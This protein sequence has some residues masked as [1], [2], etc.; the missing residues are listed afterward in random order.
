MNAFRTFDYMN[1]W[2]EWHDCVC[3]HAKHVE[4]FTSVINDFVCD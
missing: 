1:D 3:L 4:Y 2:S